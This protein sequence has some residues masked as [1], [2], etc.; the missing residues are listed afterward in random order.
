MRSRE[1]I[2]VLLREA[3]GSDARLSI[4]DGTNVTPMSVVTEIAKRQTGDT[5]DIWWVD[6]GPPTTFCLRHEGLTAITFS[7]RALELTAQA[8]WLFS[9]SQFATRLDELAYRQALTRISEHLLTVKH[10]RLAVAAFT[11]S[12]RDQTLWCTYGTSWQHLEYEPINEAYMAQ[13]FFGFAHEFGHIAAS[14]NPIALDS[15]NQ[16]RA[17]V[18]SVVGHVLKQYDRFPQ[19][20][21]QLLTEKSKSDDSGLSL[22]ITTLLDECLA[23]VFA[24]S[25]LHEATGEVMARQ[26]MSF[27]F[28]RFAYEMLAVGAVRN[29]FDSAFRFCG[30]FSEATEPKKKALEALSQFVSTTVRAAVIQ[31]FLARTWQASESDLNVSQGIAKLV[32]QIG[33][34][35]RRIEDATGRAMRFMI[36]AK[37]TESEL[38]LQATFLQALSSPTSDQMRQATAHFCSLADSFGQSCPAIVVLRQLVG[39]DA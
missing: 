2:D 33:V 19:E 17:F 18:E 11:E 38:K 21:K 22:G 12:I 4:C 9:N 26:D 30:W 39:S 6:N 3:V 1:L 14:S 37:Q 35:T 27:K 23:D 20:I 5:V 13:W 31:F 34:D 16:L 7:T 8:R 29:A 15:N 36:R 28:E 32:E 25:V 10:P 24:C